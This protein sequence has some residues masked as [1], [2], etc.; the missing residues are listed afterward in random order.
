MKLSI[1]TTLYK[2]A[3]Y[4]EEFYRRI[5]AEA[6]K[7]TDDYEIIMVDDGSPDN[8]LDIAVNILKNDSR[9]RVIELSRNFGHHKAIMTGIEHAS[10]E[11]VFLIDVDLE[12][13]PAL[14]MEFYLLMDDKWDVV[15][16]YQERRK[17]GWFEK[18]SGS[19]AWWFIN[20]MFPIK[21]PYNHS[22]VRL[23]KRNYAQA[24]IRHKEHK[25]A[26]GGLWV[27]TGFKQTGIPFVKSSRN[28]SGYSFRARLLM[29][30]DSVTSFSEMPLYII[31]FMGLVILCFS[32]VFGMHLIFRRLVGTILPGWVSVMV[33]VWFLGGLAIFCIGV[34]GLYISRIFIE[35]KKRPYTIIRNFHKKK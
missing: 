7:I 25:T 28:K 16:G 15:Y 34:V 2:S 32:G 24:L 29:L 19:V 13:P 21:I 31:F 12:E 1:V 20:L 4:I 30:F 11:L 3:P 5:S 14:L 8:S 9:F 22:T 26:I 10:G 35:T 17:G 18:Y 27:L 23:M 33:S 6:R